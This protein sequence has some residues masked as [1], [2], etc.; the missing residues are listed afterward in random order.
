M[1]MKPFPVWP[2]ECCVPAFVCF[3][4]DHFGLECSYPQTLPAILGVKVHADQDNPLHLP[5]AT[6]A[7]PVG[8]RAADAERE[9]NRLFSELGSPV[10]FR[11]IPFDEVT[12]G[13]WEDVLESALS[14]DIVV[15][16]GVD[17]AV[18]TGK[19]VRRPARHLV[20]VTQQAGD[21]L[22]LYDDS[23]EMGTAA[24]QC[25]IDTA[26]SAVQAVP[27]GFWMIGVPDDL[28]LPLT[29]PWEGRV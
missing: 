3:A 20:R 12:F 29:L 24:F 5:I 4:L 25:S 7:S 10:T 21:Y 1:I 16:L 13:L 2:P 22:S 6:S 15:G 18:L 9:I 19:P 23:G 27:D 17:Y 11:R 14:R 26:R 28:Q 8:I